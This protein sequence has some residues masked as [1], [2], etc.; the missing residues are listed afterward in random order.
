MSRSFYLISNFLISGLLIGIL[1]VVPNLN[2]MLK[3]SIFTLFAIILSA[4]LILDYPYPTELFDLKVRATSV[5]TCI[6]ISRIGAAAGTFL[7]PVLTN[8]GGASLA[9]L[10]CAIV[11]LFA[12]VVCLIWAPETSPPIYKKK[13]TINIPRKKTDCT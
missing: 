10:V 5:G 1:V 11:L 8:V 6:T 4:G 12:F 3:L 7:L 9:M 2:S 13:K